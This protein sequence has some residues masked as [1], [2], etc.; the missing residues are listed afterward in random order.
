MATPAAA[1]LARWGIALELD[2]APAAV[3]EAAAHHLLDTLGCGLAA[4]GMGEGLAGARVAAENGGR[5]EATALG[6][7]ERVPA[8]A[9]ALA[10]GMLCHALDFDDTHEASVS[11]ISTVVVPAAIAV[12][13]SRRA[14]GAE[15]LAAVLAGSETVARIGM[16]AH[17]A[18]HA[19]GFHPTSVCGVFGATLAAARLMGLDEERATRALGLAGSL[20]SGVFEY[21]SDGSPTKP[22]HAGWAAQAGVQAAA[23][24]AAGASGPATI[25][26]GRFG[27][28]ATHA[29]GAADIEAQLADLGERWETPQI[30][31][32]PYPACHFS[33]A[34]VDAAVEAAGDAA[35][36]DIEEI[37]VRIPPGGVP[38]VLEPAAAKRSPRTAYDAKF[39]LPWCVAARLA[40]GRLDARSFD[41]A[42]VADPDILA[43]A[44]RV[45]HEPWPGPQASSPF[46]GAATVRRRDGSAREATVNS[47][48][49]TP[50][51]P[52]TTAAVVEKYMASAG[53]A[54][55]AGAAG[56]L[57]EAV[58]DLPACADVR[59]PLEVLTGAR[60]AATAV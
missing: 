60:T 12:A 39:S 15:L 18:F 40:D 10:N 48:R 29:E 23:L 6:A 44:G 16:A 33:H 3:A 49:G 32:K 27:L 30:A 22:L 47:P 1:R 43:L 51:N 13:E 36:G 42:H 54:L 59:E 26:E 58:L 45:R 52:L 55:E 21:L 53:L 19:R 17:G 57:A 34:A 5:G 7:A 38:I 28:Y 14:S 9:A 8:S 31:F 2:D 20:A 4:L 25:L 41:D 56:R 50:E 37:V 24:A 11:H 35:L 46:A